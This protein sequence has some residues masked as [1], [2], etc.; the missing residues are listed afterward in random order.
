MTTRSARR[1]AALALSA[2][3]SALTAFSLQGPTMKASHLSCEFREDPLGID[4][5]HPRLGWVVESPLRG[6]R[7]TAY[8]ILVAST[9]EH[10]SADRGDLWD[11]GKIPGD[12]TTMIPYN[13]EPLSSHRRCFWKVM[14]WDQEGNSGSWSGP[15]SWS[16]G[17]LD[18]A[19]WNASWI[20]YDA[21]RAATQPDSSWKLP[22]GDPVLLPPPRYAPP[23]GCR[24][25]VR[26]RHLR[27]LPRQ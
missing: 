3:V 15:A 11:S 16:M 8:R 14:L 7:Q 12:Q 22:K 24:L 23:A 20:G 4:T 1:I 6:A 13:G 5:R 9:P 18:P 27:P 26:P 19:E 21:P 17:V 2:A 25:R 10:L